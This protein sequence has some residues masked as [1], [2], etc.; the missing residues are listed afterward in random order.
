[1]TILLVGGVD[2]AGLSG[3]AADVRAVTAHRAHAAPVVAALTSQNTR[4]VRRVDPVGREVIEAQLAAVLDDL[5]VAAVKVGLLA[6]RPAAEALEAALERL[7]GVPVV[8]DPVL[9]SSTGRELW[10]AGDGVAGLRRLLPRVT[11]VTPNA[12]EAA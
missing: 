1:R 11:V 12:P 10:P 5:K 4:A 9:G 2:P 8:L 7:P 3:L 6:A